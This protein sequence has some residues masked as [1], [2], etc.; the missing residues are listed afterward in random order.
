[1]TKAKERVA[2]ER[3]REY[4]LESDWKEKHGGNES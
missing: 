2:R 3:E 4:R 1:M